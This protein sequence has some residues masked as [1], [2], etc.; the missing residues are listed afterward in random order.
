M[1]SFVERVM[2]P[3]SRS[4]GPSGLL[5]DYKFIKSQEPSVHVILFSHG[6]G[7]TL[8]QS[9]RML[10]ALS[11]ACNINVFSYEYPGYGNCA[12]VATADSV[13]ANIK[14]AHTILVE[15][16]DFLPENIILVGQSIGTGP[17]LWLTS[18]IFTYHSMILISPFTS[19]A[20]LIS[21]Y[22][23]CGMQ[24]I[25]KLFIS[26]HYDNIRHIERC[27][28]PVMFIHGNN[29][30]VIPVEMSGSLFFACPSEHKRIHI[31]ANG[32]HNVGTW[33]VHEMAIF[34]HQK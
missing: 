21:I 17:T 33:D 15:S 22:G 13:N 25:F 34:I 14:Q 20:D 26:D 31:V 2:F 32:T 7:I 1:D 11:D 30:D 29:D 18:E 6:N 23:L 16:Y 10:Q 9:T 12:G 3:L 8:G 24:H 28:A 19:I 5:I 27:Y 4:T